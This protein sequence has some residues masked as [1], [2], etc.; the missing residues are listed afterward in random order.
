MNQ[1]QKDTY[2][3]AVKVFLKNKNNQLLIIKDIFDDGWDLPGGRLRKVDFNVPLEKVVQR[4]IK[5]ELGNKLKYKLGQ[6]AIFFRHQRTELPP[7]GHGEKV[8]IFAIGYRASYISG[9]ITLPDY[10]KKVSWVNL[11]NFNPTKYFKGG[12]LKGV[13]EYLNI[14]NK[15]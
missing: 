15:R 10:I 11:K 9:E 8:R 12:W 4:K 3:V 2:F 5:E 14:R 6:P 7:E 13:R 1:K